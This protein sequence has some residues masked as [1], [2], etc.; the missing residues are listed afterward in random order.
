MASLDI[1]R[2]KYAALSDSLTERSRRLWAGTEADALGRGGIALVAK[3]TGLAIS[4]VRKG[5]D[6]VRSPIDPVDLVLE[7][8]RGG[9]R[10]RLEK[11]DPRLLQTLERLVAPSERGDPESPLRWTIKSLR[12]LSKELSAVGVKASAQKGAASSGGR[13]AGSSLPGTT[14]LMGGTSTGDGR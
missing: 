5:R 2:R 11:K 10:I 9:G 1:L 8:R 6:E 12:T 3:A 13:L 14:P 7:R 4:T